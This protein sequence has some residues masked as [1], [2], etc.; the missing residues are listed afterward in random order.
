VNIFQD[1]DGNRVVAQTPNLPIII[2]FVFFTIS[3]ISRG[4]VSDH[5]AW[6]ARL[7]LG[8]WAILEITQGENTFRRLLG[9]T[10]LTI[11][12]LSGLRHI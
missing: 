4:D 11:A 10:G 6:V 3:I 2:W 12:I 8:T 9:L 5:A 1:K 7:A